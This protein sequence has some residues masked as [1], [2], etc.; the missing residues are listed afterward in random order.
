MTRQEKIAYNK[1]IEDV[2][3]GSSLSVVHNNKYYATSAKTLDAL[4]KVI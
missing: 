4:K 1:A 2:R 3:S